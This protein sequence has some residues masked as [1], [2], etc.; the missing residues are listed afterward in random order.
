[1]SGP[2]EVIQVV[3]T[4]LEL[5]GDGTRD[6]PMRRLTQ[7]WSLDGVLLA[8]VDPLPGSSKDLEPGE[9]NRT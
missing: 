3:R 6:S 9:G 5:R 1:M 4:E 8:E 2:V 7:F